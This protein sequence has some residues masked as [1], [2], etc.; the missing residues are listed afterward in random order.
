MEYLPLEI[1]VEIF[2]ELSTKELLNAKLV[3]RSW[4]HF[5]SIEDLIWRF[6]CLKR[7]FGR[8]NIAQY[9][10][11]WKMM[12]MDDNLRTKSLEWEWDKNRCG[13]GIHTFHNNRAAV[14][15]ASNY[16]ACQVL[17]SKSCVRD[18]RYYFEVEIIHTV[19]GAINVGISSQNVDLERRCGFDGNGWSFSLYSGTL[20]HQNTWAN[21]SSYSG[22][23]LGAG[24]RIGMAIDMRN[25]RIIFF[26]NGIISQGVVL[27]RIPS[28]VFPSVS[29]GDVGDCV[30]IIPNPIIPKF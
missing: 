8:C 16:A 2:S 12:L 25:R 11:S 7:W 21:R 28:E 20:F 14:F 24:S 4:C 19:R 1:V 6:I 27:E 23:L 9:G 15:Q 3:C 10:G 29:L 22:P 5:I 13:K 30:A 18:E 17:C 26:F